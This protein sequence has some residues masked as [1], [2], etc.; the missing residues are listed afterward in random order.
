MSLSRL[1][2]GQGKR[3]EART[4]LALVYNWCTAGLDTAD[5]QEARRCWRIC[6]HR[7]IMHTL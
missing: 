7:G 6:V 4:L 5:L 3:I 1:W 2:Q